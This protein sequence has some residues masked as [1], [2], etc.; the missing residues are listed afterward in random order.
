[1]L[2]GRQTEILGVNR[3]QF[4]SQSRTDVDENIWY[5]IKV[6][7]ITEI[8]A[9]TFLLNTWMFYGSMD[10]NCNNLSSFVIKSIFRTSYVEN[11]NVNT[12]LDSFLE[13][14]PNL[15]YV[16]NTRLVSLIESSS[17]RIKIFQNIKYRRMCNGKIRGN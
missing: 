14:T 3:I 8:C 12:F 15:I 16:Y 5:S 7:L 10:W 6:C 17:K 2:K 1:M 4:A 11:I 9:F 13:H